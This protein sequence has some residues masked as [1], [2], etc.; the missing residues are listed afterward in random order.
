MKAIE[1]DPADPETGWLVVDDDGAIVVHL[2]PE[3]LARLI[4]QRLSN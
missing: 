3:A 2:L 4:A 1:D